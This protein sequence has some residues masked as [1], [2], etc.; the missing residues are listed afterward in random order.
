MKAATSRLVKNSASNRVWEGHDFSRAAKSNK[1]GRASAP[2]V[3]FLLPKSRFLCSPSKL[4]SGPTERPQPRIKTRIKKRLTTSQSRHPTQL[5][6]V[7]ADSE[8]NH[9]SA[10]P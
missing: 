10:L 6:H 3:G 4:Q 1:V 8:R 5:R 9:G 7:Q 2:E